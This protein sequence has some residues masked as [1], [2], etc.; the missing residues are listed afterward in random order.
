[1]N[2]KLPMLLVFLAAAGCAST[3]PAAKQARAARPV[4]AKAPASSPEAE[5]PALP[6]A[7]ALAEAD[8][9]Y[10][11]QMGASRGQFGVDRQVLVLRQAVYLY[12]QFLERAEGRPELEPA[13]RKSRERIEDAQAT[14]DFLLQHTRPADGEP[15][16]GSFE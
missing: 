8:R 12:G 14:I 2:A 1:M 3:G 6:P 11:S 10:E 7:E 4:A 5:A 15:P 16:H 13:V 9:A